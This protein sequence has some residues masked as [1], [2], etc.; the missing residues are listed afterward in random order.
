LFNRATFTHAAEFENST[1][2]RKWRTRAFFNDAP[3]THAANFK[4]ATASAEVWFVLATFADAALF[5]ET[6]FTGHVRLSG[7]EVLHLDRPS[8]NEVRSWPPGWTVRSD[9]ADSGRG[10]LEP[11]ERDPEQPATPPA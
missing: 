9:P 3:F 8:L 10:T 6:T 1:L 2:Q 4:G 5:T 7:A 11:V